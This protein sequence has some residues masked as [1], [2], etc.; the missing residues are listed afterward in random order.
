M[1]L[2]MIQFIVFCCAHCFRWVGATYGNAMQRGERTC[3][4]LMMHYGARCDEAG[5][6][7]GS[8]SIQLLASCFQNL[9]DTR[10]IRNGLNSLQ[11][12]ESDLF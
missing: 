3:V 9:I 2:P 8:S 12:K 7:G 10:T 5:V 4:S 6:L 11:T 1:D